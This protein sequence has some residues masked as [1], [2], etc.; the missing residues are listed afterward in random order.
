MDLAMRV[1]GSFMMWYLLE[2]A[3]EAILVTIFF[4]YIELRDWHDYGLVVFAV[5]EVGR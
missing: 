1:D 2:M 4:F 3:I 5:I